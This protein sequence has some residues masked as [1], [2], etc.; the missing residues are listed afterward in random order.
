MKRLFPALP[1][2]ALIALLAAA[3]ALAGMQDFSL[4]NNAASAIVSFRMSPAGEDAFG[5]NMFTE[6]SLAPGASLSGSFPNP[7]NACLW[8]L[9]VGLADGGESLV[10]GVDL[11]TAPDM[12]YP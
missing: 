5:E 11:C 10:T 9:K 4:T 8:D 2:C 1:C 3:P 7:D 6:F 12:T